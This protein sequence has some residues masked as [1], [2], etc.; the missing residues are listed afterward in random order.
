MAWPVVNKIK[1]YGAT[2]PWRTLHIS[3][4]SGVILHAEVH[5][6]INLVVFMWP[7][8]IVGGVLGPFYSSL[9]N[10]V[11]STFLPFTQM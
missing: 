8:G 7:S 11:Q 5:I 2:E 10:F 9:D 6:Y 4:F 3:S 1:R